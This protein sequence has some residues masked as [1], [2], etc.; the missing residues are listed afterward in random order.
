MS[1]V[2]ALDLE[3]Y[4]MG[5]KTAFLNGDL[6]EEIFMQQPDGYKVK[7]QENKVYKL[8][9]SLY[10]LKQASRQ[11]YY[12]F[13]N[14]IVKF[15]FRTNDYD[16]CVYHWNSGSDFII[17]SLYVDDIFIAG[18]HVESICE[19]KDFLKSQFEMKDLGE[20]SY[21]LGIQIIRDRKS[22]ILQLS[23]EQYIDKILK[24]FYMDSSNPIDT[25]IHKQTKLS[26]KMCPINDEEKRKMEHRPYT[27]V[28]GSIMYAM[29]CTKPNLS[30]TISLVGRFQSN[31]GEAHWIAVKRILRYIRGT[32]SHKMTYSGKHLKVIGYSDSSFSGG[33]DDEKC[34]SGYVLLLRGGA[35][36]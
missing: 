5:V 8:K 14:A 6:K 33:T 30:F 9:K 23:Q 21:V 1:I 12:T 19:V 20:A 24:R 31:P 25:P 3:L 35:I 4:Q 22:I 32:K 16:H 11:W 28:L 10:G 17:L 2:S 26:K 13:H 29:L 18:N 7:G 34:T 15:G 27:Q 36:S